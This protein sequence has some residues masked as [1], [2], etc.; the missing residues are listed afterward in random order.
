MF[1]GRS[2]SLGEVWLGIEGAALLRCLLDGDEAFVA[3]RVAA[4]EALVGR[5]GGGPFAVRSPV[6]ELGVE[7]GYR[8]WA[9]AYDE[10]S[11]ALIRAE[12]PLVHAGLDGVA[13][14]VALDAACGTGRLAGMLAGRGHRTL[15]VDRSDAMLAR[16]R[17]K[18]AGVEFR[19]GDLSLLPVESGSFDVAT[20]GL[21]LTHLADPGPAICELA[22]VVRPGGRVAIS[23]AHPTFV[24]VQGQALFPTGSGFA[25]VRNHHHAHS[26]YLRAFRS[27]GLDVL[28]CAEAPM[29]ADFTEGLTAGAPDAAVALWAGV[30]VVLVWTLQRR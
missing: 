29:E 22:Q 7:E 9:P 16:A 11:N 18:L 23:D 20:C 28:D 30:P 13:A 26:V 3:A 6:P 8:A 5:L 25:F 17:E 4:I 15:G 27:A 2:V 21:A 12:E 10:M 19:S 1:V 24:A 14:G